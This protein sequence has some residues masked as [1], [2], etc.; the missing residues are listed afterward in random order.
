MLTL[1][2]TIPYSVICVITPTQLLREA[3]DTEPMLAKYYRIIFFPRDHTVQC[4]GR[5]CHG[6]LK[7]QPLTVDPAPGVE[8]LAVA[9]N[10]VNSSN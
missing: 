8:Q 1:T 6:T 9:G 5:P 7:L 10:D 2:R 4:A 3:L